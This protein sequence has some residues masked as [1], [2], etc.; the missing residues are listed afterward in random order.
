MELSWNTPNNH[1]KCQNIHH[2]INP[3]CMT[4]IFC[5]HLHFTSACWMLSSATGVLGLWNLWRSVQLNHCQLPSVTRKSMNARRCSNVRIIDL[6]MSLQKPSNFFM[7]FLPWI[8]LLP[9]LPDPWSW[10]TY[11]YITWTFSLFRSLSAW[12]AN[13]PATKISP[14][15]IFTLNF[16]CFQLTSIGYKSSRHAKL[17]IVSDL[18]RLKFSHSVEC[19]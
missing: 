1:T 6:L 19:K 8:V 3:L 17:T 4:L 15:L 10:S 9:W 5:V 12:H 16:T 13:P 14:K 2:S 7:L 11:S 18:C